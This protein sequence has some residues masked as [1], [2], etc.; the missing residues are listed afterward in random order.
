MSDQ[1]RRTKGVSFGAPS[2]AEA[3]DEASHYDAEPEPHTDEPG[4]EAAEDDDA[5]VNPFAFTL[6]SFTEIAQYQERE[7]A[8][9]A[10]K[11]RQRGSLKLHETQAGR[12]RR[13]KI[14]DADDAD[15]SI[16]DMVA[17]QNPKSQEL[18]IS[19]RDRHIEKEHLC[20]YIQKK[21]DM[22][23]V[24]Y[25]LEVKRSEMDKLD[26]ITAT[27]E[28]R[29]QV[30]EQQLEMDGKKFYE[31]LK[32]NDK[33][34]A[35][36][37]RQAENQ[38][39]VKAE[40]VAEIKAL[41][42]EIQ[43]LQST[44]S[45]NDDRLKELHIYIGFLDSLAPPEWVAAKQKRLA[46]GGGGGGFG[47]GVS[48]ADGGGAEECEAGPAAEDGGDGE[49]GN[50][51]APFFTTPQQLLKVFSE[52]EGHNLSL[53]TNGQEV[54]ESLQDLEDKILE[55]QAQ[56]LDEQN[57][58]AAK[59]IEL[60]RK[61]AIESDHAWFGKERASYFSSSN[62]EKQEEE[63]AALEE[64]VGAVYVECI[65]ENEANISALQMLTNIENKLEELFEM[66]AKMPADKVEAAEK[67]KEKQ[68]RLRA[69]EEK[70]EAQKLHQEERVRKA[71]E[72]AQ[73]APKR[74]TGKKLMYRS[75][76]PK[77]KKKGG[78]RR[79]QANVAEEEERYFFGE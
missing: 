72:R 39:K 13:V 79:A 68:R 11:A 62:T 75:A 47:Y 59:N 60:E 3:A 61:I 53:I 9:R 19:T 78:N 1:P 38:T 7:R 15:V 69:R 17:L 23:L 20:E 74:T 14:P 26:T 36:A 24:Q 54:E 73:A 40:K 12:Q 10:E 46:G 2:E 50:A 29:I 76:P 28:R 34:S 44:L 45:K 35:E 21:R 77:L 51:N 43:T 32:E 25:A 52:L 48:E 49:A 56:M 41:E 70:L 30:A 18:A 6:P 64:K 71:L 63:M 55:E 4:R 22:F 65:G 5:E 8:E 58:L 27:E 16:N 66:I 67:A 37:V 57:A 42:S 33:T 31:F